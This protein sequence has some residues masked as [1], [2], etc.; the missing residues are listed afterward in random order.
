[1][2][3]GKGVA[4]LNSTK[5]YATLFEAEGLSYDNL[6]IVTVIH[7]EED[8][9]DVRETIEHI[10]KNRGELLDYCSLAWKCKIRKG[11]T[12]LVWVGYEYDRIFCATFKNENESETA[13]RLISMANA[14]NGLENVN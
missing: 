7:E 4:I 8:R 2:E 1:M 5:S 3:W 14:L 10:I 9:D 13:F 6:Q 12:L 11:E